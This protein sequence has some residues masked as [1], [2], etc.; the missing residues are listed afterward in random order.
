M[1]KT[2]QSCENCKY[3]KCFEPTDAKSGIWDGTCQK[4]INSPSTGWPPF[5]SWPNVR[6]DST[7]GF[8]EQGPNR[9]SDQPVSIAA[10]TPSPEAV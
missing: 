4:Q 3:F 7:C 1:N 10:Q 9:V 5:E 6:R 8:F 2:N